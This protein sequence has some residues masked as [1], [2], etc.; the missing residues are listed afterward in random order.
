M[1]KNDIYRTHLRSMS[2]D[3]LA[4]AGIINRSQIRRLNQSQMVDI[5]NEL[6]SHPDTSAI[7][8]SSESSESGNPIQDA[9]NA[10]NDAIAQQS[11]GMDEDRVNDMIQDKMKPVLD[12]VADMGG[13]VD[14]LAPL[15]D[16]LQTIAD[17]MT[18]STNSRLPIATAVA[19]GSSPLLKVLD[20]YYK[21][22]VRSET[23]VCISAPPSYGKSYSINILGKSYDHC[24]QHGC[25]G[26]V[27]EW[28]RLLG[29]ATVNPAG[30]FLIEDGLLVQAVRL[31]SSGEK[32][33][34]FLDECFRMRDE[35]ME[36]LLTFLAPQS[37]KAGEKVYRIG[38]MQ[39][40]DG[41]IE[42][43]EC[44]MENLHIVTATN[45]SNVTPPE[46]FLD[47]F[48]IKHIQYDETMIANIC[49]GIATS[50]GIDEPEVIAK[51]FAKG[52]SESR[53]RKT[54]GQ[55]LRPL[56]VRDFNRGCTHTSSAN[57]TGVVNWLSENA[58]DGMCQWESETGDLIK[59]SVD[60]A[61]CVIGTIA[62]AVAPF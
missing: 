12:E 56:S 14:A 2:D 41:V 6:G 28:S 5:C 16:T 3:Q 52:M 21:A 48:L 20:P 55:L 24:I 51:A 54:S 38:T 22:G 49:E 50:F 30:G 17:A 61:N 31:A 43:I 60:G 62:D 32:V 4:S 33:L 18:S 59:D 29:K 36:S 57:P 23:P 47:R 27:D 35:T 53:K 10:L 25:A 44:S 19:S 11:T 15:A 58:K 9:M 26:D 40:K 45:L 7:S 39:S 13:K 37:N 1:N 42:Q 46:A 8:A 34:F